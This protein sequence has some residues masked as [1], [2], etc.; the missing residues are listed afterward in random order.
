MYRKTTRSRE[1]IAR[2]IA[3]RDRRP[4][5]VRHNRKEQE[6]NDADQRLAVVGQVEPSVRR[7][8]ERI[9]S[10]DN[11]RFL[12]LF[13][14]CNGFREVCFKCGYFDPRERAH[15]RCHVMGSCPAASLSPRVI[16]YVLHGPSV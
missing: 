8:M 11:G 10:V 1:Q 16:Q 7:S 12:P 14:A 3:A 4:R 6:M 5:R 2:M 9:A 13:R 15:Y